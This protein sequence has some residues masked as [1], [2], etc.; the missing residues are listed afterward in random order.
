MSTTP[1]VVPSLSLLSKLTFI[2]HF[3]YPSFSRAGPRVSFF[4]SNIAGDFT[5]NKL[6]SSIQSFTNMVQLLLPILSACIAGVAARSSLMERH[7][8]KITRNMN[9]AALVERQMPGE[10]TT[11]TTATGPNGETITITVGVT[12]TQATMGGSSNMTTINQPPMAMGQTH[13]VGQLESIN[14]NS[15]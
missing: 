2:C 15:S 3:R 8:H 1:A 13:M 4:A 14:G 9:D 5:F 7:A 10:Q 12:I 6:T 11:T